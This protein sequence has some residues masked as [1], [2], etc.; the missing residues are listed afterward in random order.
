MP[1]ITSESTHCVPRMEVL[2]ML[3]KIFQVGETRSENFWILPLLWVKRTKD[4]PN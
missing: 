3:D 4:T 2:P 1:K